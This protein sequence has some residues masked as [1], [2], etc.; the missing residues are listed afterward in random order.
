M[1]TETRSELV[2][3]LT[4]KGRV[5]GVVDLEST[6]AGYF[7]EYHERFLMT[8]ASRM[9]SAL[10]NAELYARVAEN[11]SRL[12]REMKIAREIQ[13]QL[14]PDEVPSR[15]RRC[16]WPY[17]SNRSRSS[18]ATFTTGSHS[19]TAASRSSSAMSRAKARP[20]R[21]MARCPAE[22]SGRAQAGN[23]RRLRCWN[24]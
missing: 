4:S 23:I 11:E 9:A 17:C 3:P 20:P 7:T 12:G 2:V 5:V 22:S 1:H 15:C 10:V 8:L 13:H 6:Q 16:S 14:M 24:S 18:E 19:M 21:C